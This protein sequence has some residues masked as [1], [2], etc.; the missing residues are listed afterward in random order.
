MCRILYGDVDVGQS[1]DSFRK[2]EFESHSSQNITFNHDKI[3]PTKNSHPRKQWVQDFL[4]K[5]I[6][7]S[8]SHGRSDVI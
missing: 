3:Y 5:I 2:S 8:G 1:L 7:S 4:P 6:C